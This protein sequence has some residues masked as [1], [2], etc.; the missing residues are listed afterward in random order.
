MP[1]GR[2]ESNAPCH[3]PS[4]EL[5]HFPGTWTKSAPTWQQDRAKTWFSS[6]CACLPEISQSQRCVNYVD[7][8]QHVPEIAFR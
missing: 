3:S 4:L 2:A 7:T 8:C 1:G 6:G 5:L